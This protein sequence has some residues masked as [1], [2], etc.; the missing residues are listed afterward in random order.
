M[1]PFDD[2][3]LLARHVW[4]QEHINA[5]LPGLL[6]ELLSGDVYGIG[7][8]RTKPPNG[9]GVYLFTS[10]ERHEYVG[11]TGLT[12]R[13]ERSGGTSYSGFEKRLNGHLTATHSSGSWAY[14][15]T[16]DSFRESGR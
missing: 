11:R 3:E 2:P 14:K 15:R 10:A 9:Y 13:T 7:S 5:R 16:C 8:G 12:E 6:S 4:W 1:D